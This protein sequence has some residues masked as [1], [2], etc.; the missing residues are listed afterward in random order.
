[1]LTVTDGIVADL[2]VAERRREEKRRLEA[3][4]Y[5][6]L[7]LCSLLFVKVL[8]LVRCSNT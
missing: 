1:M 8:F 5:N 4:S 2:Y 3:D 7:V 6:T